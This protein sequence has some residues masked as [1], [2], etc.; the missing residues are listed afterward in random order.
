MRLDCAVLREALIEKGYELLQQA[1]GIAYADNVSY[2]TPNF[3]GDLIVILDENNLS[4]LD[5]CAPHIHSIVCIGEMTGWTVMKSGFTCDILLAPADVTTIE[6]LDIVSRLF[7]DYAEW[8]TELLRCALKPESL[9]R[10][11]EISAKMLLNPIAVLDHNFRIL[12]RSEF[13]APLP[14]GTIWDV[15]MGE[16]LRMT[17]FYSARERKH[18][19]EATQK[20]PTRD[21]LFHPA[22][23][24]AHQYYT[25]IL[26]IDDALAGTIGIADVYVPLS[27]GQCAVARIVRDRLED[28][29]RR[30]QRQLLLEEV[31]G[32]FWY[33]VLTGKSVDESELNGRLSRRA[34]NRQDSYI[35]AAFL[36][37]LEYY[38]QMELMAALNQ[39]LVEYPRAIFAVEGQAILMLCRR[40]DYDLL[41]D[42]KNNRQLKD[43]ELCAGISYVMPEVTHCA[44]GF[45]QCLFAAKIARKEG[46]TTRHYQ[47]V[48]AAHILET[49]DDAEPHNTFCDPRVLA[50][51]NS[52]RESDRQLLLCLKAYLLNG[53]NI[54][55]TA[56]ALFLHRNT[57]IYR[58][59]RLEK[60]LEIQFEHLTDKQLFSLLMSCLLCENKM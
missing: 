53:R 33:E 26:T 18:I 59:E 36:P 38:A 11:L 50:L 54:A 9:S 55:D 7:R 20:S 19:A 14:E 52:P 43:S 3:A 56:R 49:L 1:E 30:N 57:L 27:S 60:V 23:D 35:M 28:Y 15:M 24:E 12:G 37:R 25:A 34:W 39:L 44:A 8:D 22:R 5:T 41:D 13:T 42:E 51:K 31:S 21:L 47:D 29:L 48:Q 4:A 2:F 58:I 16:R 10:F 32:G 45:R 6:A 40:D 46:T 17:E